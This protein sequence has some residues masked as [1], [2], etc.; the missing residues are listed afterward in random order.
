MMNCVL[1]GRVGEFARP[2]IMFK[3]E[4]IPVTSGLAT[5]AAERV[6]DLVLLILMFMLTMS[7]V[8]IDPGFSLQFSNI[9]LNKATLESIEDKMIILC[10][11]LISGIILVMIEKSRKIINLVIMHFPDYLF[12]LGTDLKKKIKNKLCVPLI[13]IVENIATG[14]AMLKNPAKTI[15]C[16]ILS[17]LIWGLVSLSYYVMSFGCPGF[18]L[19]LIEMSMVMV[20]I[21]FF[22]SLPSVPGYWGI[23]EAGGIFAMSLFGISGKDA[24]GFILANHAIQILPIVAAGLISAMITGTGIMK[25]MVNIS[26]NPKK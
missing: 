23:W 22:I 19:S 1:P 10:I 11:L 20:I 9:I 17:I 4:S 14:F 12:F 8:D 6:F 26:K 21:C 3:Q 16:F 15:T 13:N 5:V 25:M 24:G 18:S 7:W 2:L